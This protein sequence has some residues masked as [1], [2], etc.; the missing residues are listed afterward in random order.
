MSLV[1]KK[2]ISVE[3]PLEG[4]GGISYSLHCSEIIALNYTYFNRHSSDVCYVCKNM[5][6]MSLVIY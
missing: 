3:P 6:V 1:S 2:G 5:F 4:S